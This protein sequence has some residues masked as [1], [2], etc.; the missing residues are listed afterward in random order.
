[1]HDRNVSNQSLQPTVIPLHGLPA[2]ELGRSTTNLH[3]PSRTPITASEAPISAQN[4]PDG[5]RFGNEK[6]MNSENRI[7]TPPPNPPDSAGR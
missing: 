6:Q 4:L 5:N 2:A 7:N 1:M 3:R